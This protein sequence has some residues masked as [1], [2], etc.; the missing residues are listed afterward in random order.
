MLVLGVVLVVALIAFLARGKLKNRFKV[1][2]IPGKLGLNIQADETG[3]TFDHAMGG[4]SRYRIHASKA[5]QYKDNHLILHEV[6]IDLYGEDGSRV[7]NITGAEFDY[8]QKANKVTAAGP[9]EITLMRPSVA[10]AIAPKAAPDRIVK[11]KSTPIANAAQTAAEGEIH[12]KTSGL[13]FDTKKR[14]RQHC[15]TCR[16]LHGPGQR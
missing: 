12:V 5:A 1:S 11:G 14:R 9:V 2:D 15:R 3:V 10:P 7:D 13:S 4:H 16:V 6:Q 8:D